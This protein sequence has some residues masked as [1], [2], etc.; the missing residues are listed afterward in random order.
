MFWI[1]KRQ[2]QHIFFL[3][4]TLLL[5]IMLGYKITYKR[6]SEKHVLIY[7]LI[8]RTAQIGD[9]LL[10]LE[11]KGKKEKKGCLRLFV[12]LCALSWIA[13]G[14][15]LQWQQQEESSGGH[16]WVHSC[17]EDTHTRVNTLTNTCSSAHKTR[18]GAFM[19]LA[20]VPACHTHTHTYILWPTR[21]W[22][23]L[24]CNPRW[25]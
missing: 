8:G 7:S 21:S 15:S 3:S 16:A 9:P 24:C 19:W 14:S 11:R 12:N 25:R 20:F 13:V 10:C 2:R 22:S 17:R 23:P 5:N 18:R 4:L 6:K 1:T